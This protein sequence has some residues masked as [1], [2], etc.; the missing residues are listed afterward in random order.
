VRQLLGE[1]LLAGPA[2]S[3][4]RIEEYAGR[5]TLDAWVRIAAIRIALNLIRGE[6]RHRDALLRL[7]DESPVS[8]DPELELLKHRYRADFEEAFRKALAALSPR[9]RSVLRLRFLDGLAVGEIAT[10][11]GV[12]RSTVTRWLASAEEAVSGE[13][14]RALRE[15]IRVRPSECDRLLDLLKSRLEVTLHTLLRRS[16]GD[17]GTG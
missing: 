13:T 2:G 5:G 16:M 11:F 14:R 3:A 4:G 8:P 15:R 12:H 9:E 17:G 10:I 7:A 1:R 6:D